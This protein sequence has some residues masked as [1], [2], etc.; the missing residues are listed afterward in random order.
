MPALESPRAQIAR[1]SNTAYSPYSFCLRLSFIALCCS[2]NIGSS[3]TDFPSTSTLQFV[4]SAVFW[5]S[6][7]ESTFSFGADLFRKQLS[8]QEKATFC[9]WN[10]WRRKERQIKSSSMKEYCFCLREQPLSFRY[11]VAALSHA[12]HLFKEN[13]FLFSFYSIPNKMFQDSNHYLN[14]YSAG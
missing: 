9:I 4:S 8:T 6:R 13:S 7:G 11:A 1:W 5:H 10:I 14:D 12:K 3:C 2:T